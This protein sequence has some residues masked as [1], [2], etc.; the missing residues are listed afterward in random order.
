MVKSHVKVQ[1]LVLEFQ[2][3]KPWLE[4][5]DSKITVKSK[6]WIEYGKFIVRV[7]ICTFANEVLHF[8]V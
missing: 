1:H 2:E 8:Y 4:V 7:P 3:L 6:S 5:I